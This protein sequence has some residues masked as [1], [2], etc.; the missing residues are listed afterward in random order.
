MDNV[1]L[2][3]YAR[4]IVKIGVNIQKGQTLVVSSPIEAA[5][6][7][8]LIA[9]TAYLEGAKDVVINW[10]D[11][12]FSK[13]RYM[14]APGEIFDTFPE[15]RKQL[16]MSY[17]AE[18]AAFLSIYAEDPELMKDVEPDR[19]IRA[20]K[21]S[22]TALKEYRRMQMNNELVWCVASIPTKAWARSVFPNCGEDQA[23]EKLWEAIF[24]T[25]RAD[26][27]DPVAAWEEHKS[28][29]K[30]SMDFMN[31]NK[32]K[33]LQYKNSAGTDLKIELPE[34]HL[35][36]GGSDYT[37]YGIEF[38]ANMPTE[39]VFTLPK[40]SGVN[41]KVVSSKPLNYNGNLIDKFSLTFKDGK[42]VDFSAEKG[43]DT[44]RMLLEAD[45]GSRYLGEVALVPYD[46]PISK[47]NIL[48][49]NT[50][51]DEN[52]SCHLALG[53]AYTPCL[54]NGD[55]L[56]EEELKKLEVNDSLI[57]EDFMVGTEDMEIT[58]ITADGK[59][60]PVF[61]KGNFAF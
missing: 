3:K 57:H 56:T 8:R 41:G 42:V 25:V 50:L 54:K 21:A 23:V 19:M 48:F 51:F 60:V 14:H 52:A 59:E 34:D 6:F 38:I 15:W 43:Y 27:T 47:S 32:F 24:K 10:T 46:S 39:E 36:V 33:Y 22:S 28:N 53:K 16:Y 13:I 40:R 55:K 49:Y 44:L 1:M 12:L 9:K 20:H 37:N 58:G 4:L 35:W 5:E 11:E 18:K 7:T 61:R 31:S 26:Q 29:L 17:A 2:E 45:E 30:K